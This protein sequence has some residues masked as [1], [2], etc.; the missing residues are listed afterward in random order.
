MPG[1]TYYSTKEVSEITGVSVRNLQTLDEGGHAR[2]VRGHGRKRHWREEDVRAVFLWAKWPTGRQGG[3]GGSFRAEAIRFWY[4]LDCP[5]QGWI[6]R[7]TTSASSAT[8]EP[9]PLGWAKTDNELVAH[10]SSIG[11]GVA[12]FLHCGTPEA[13]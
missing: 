3:W 6:V 5:R 1:R 12:E 13:P 2:P 11:G 9:G 8:R 4:A 7:T 10:L